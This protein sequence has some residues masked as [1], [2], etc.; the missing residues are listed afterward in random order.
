M[1]PIAPKGGATEVMAKVVLVDQRFPQV[2]CTEEKVYCLPNSLQY[3]QAK[4]LPMRLNLQKNYLALLL[5]WPVTGQPADRVYKWIDAQGQMSFSSRPP[6][7]V[8]KA[9]VEIIIPKTN[10]IKSIPIPSQAQKKSA[11]ATSR[12]NHKLPAS[13]RIDKQQLLCKRAQNNLKKVRARLRA[14]YQYG[15]YSRLHAREAKYRG[16]RKVYCR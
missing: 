9:G 11:H 15:Q 2:F 7:Q 4:E 6:Q 14:G 10:V 12:N 13:A 16:Q 1:S 8:H 5:C 3:S